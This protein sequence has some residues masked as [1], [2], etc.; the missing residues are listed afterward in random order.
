[1]LDRLPSWIETT[2]RLLKPPNEPDDRLPS[3]HL[4]GFFA[5]RGYRGPEVLVSSQPY[6]KAYPVTDFLERHVKAFRANRPPG[7]RFDDRMLERDVLAL[8][9]LSALHDAVR[10]V[11]AY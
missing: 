2:K 7:A 9:E 11:P 5:L 6:P 3:E 8:E 4:I 1:M 10:V